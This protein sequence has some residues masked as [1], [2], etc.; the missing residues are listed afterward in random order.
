M[1]VLLLFLGV[2]IASICSA[3]KVIGCSLLSLQYLYISRTLK[4]A[5][6]IVA[7]TSHPGH[8]LFEVLPSGRRLQSIRTKTSRHKN[9]L[10]PSVTVLINNTHDP[11]GFLTHVHGHY[12]LK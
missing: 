5:V 6:K 3:E 11:L 10:F 2:L 12:T 9:C 4:R 8:K 7:D 1:G